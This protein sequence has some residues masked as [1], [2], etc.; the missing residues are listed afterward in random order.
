MHPSRRSA[1][2]CRAQ[3]GLAGRVACASGIDIGHTN[4][5]VDIDHAPIAKAM[6]LSGLRA[7]KAVVE[8]ALRTFVRRKDQA[9]ILELRGKI[10]WDGD[11]DRTR[12]ERDDEAA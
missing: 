1:S 12:R 10:Q 9:R 2:T 4:I 5:D 8:E 3:R 6:R 7:K 11:L